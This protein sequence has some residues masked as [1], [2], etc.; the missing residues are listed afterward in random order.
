MDTLF[1]GWDAVGWLYI[2]VAVG[3]SVLF[4]GSL[5]LID[6]FRGGKRAAERKQLAHGAS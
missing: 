1:D 4:Y 5:K 6:R 2:Y 3:L